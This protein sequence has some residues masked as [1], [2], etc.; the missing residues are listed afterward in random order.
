MSALG[1]TY[2]LDVDSA[3]VRVRSGT[4]ARTMEVDSST[5]LDVD[6]HGNLLSVEVLMVRQSYPFEELGAKLRDIEPDV[7]DAV[8]DVLRGLAASNRN[9]SLQPA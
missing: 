8:L 3:A 4:V 6:E 1:Y 2:D 9:G 7:A 5:L